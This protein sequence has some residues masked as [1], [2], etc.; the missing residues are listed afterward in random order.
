MIYIY[1][2]FGLGDHILCNGLVREIAKREGEVA[3]FCKH[4]NFNT[5]QFMFRDNPLIKIITVCGDEEACECLKDKRK[6]DV[7]YLGYKG[8]GWNESERVHFDEVFYRQARINFEHKYNSF[9]IDRD[10]ESEY[11]LEGEFVFLHDDPGREITINKSKVGL[12]LPIIMPQKGDRPIFAYLSIMEAAC[13]IHCIDSAFL[14]LADVMQLTCDKYFHSY[15]RKADYF[16]TPKIKDSWQ[17]IGE[18]H[19]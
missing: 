10:V 1:H 18:T 11:H 13:E 12:K 3:V 17:E 16:N 9:Y 6:S 5:V 2:H 15:A 14:C 7:L 19:A 4:H 8:E